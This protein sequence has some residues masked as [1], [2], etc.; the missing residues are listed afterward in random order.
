[1]NFYQLYNLINENTVSQELKKLKKE[2]PSTIEKFLP[3]I[4]KQIKDFLPNINDKSLKTVANWILFLYF[5]FCKQNQIYNASLVTFNRY[6]TNNLVL[7]VHGAY[8]ASQLDNNGNW[9]AILSSKFN[10]PK[11]ALYDLANLDRDYHENLKKK[12]RN[13]PGA[14][15]KTIIEFPDGY[16]WV[17]LEKSYCEKESKSMGHCGNAGASKGDTIL[18]LRDN[19]NVPHLTFILN[20]GILGERKGRANE[21][22]APKYHPYIIELLKLPIIKNLGD[23]KYLPQKDFKISDI[24]EEQL[25]SLVKIKPYF[26]IKYYEEKLDSGEKV[27]E[28]VQ[29]NLIN[30]TNMSNEEKYGYSSLIFKIAKFSESQK[31]LKELY[32]KTFEDNIINKQILTLVLMSNPHIDKEILK[33]IF[34]K[35]KN[36]LQK[37]D[38]KLSK[39]TK[40]ASEADNEILKEIIHMDFSKIG[41]STEDV[42]KYLRVS[43]SYIND[44]SYKSV[45]IT[46]LN[47]MSKNENISGELLITL[48]EDY[49]IYLALSNVNIPTKF[50]EK[51]YENAENT[52]IGKNILEYIVMNKKCPSYILDDIAE[53]P[54]HLYGFSIK[55]TVLNNPNLSKES[56]EK[57]A[58]PKIDKNNRSINYLV[59][60]QDLKSIADSATLKLNRIKS[61]GY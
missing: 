17:D 55:N 25:K 26:E 2:N 56:L 20:N 21:K 3:L 32:Q 34:D 28:D 46:I 16:K 4:Y 47:E 22:P 31:I 7:Y 14:E 6:L 24:T 39:L 19:K 12:Q 37:D 44:G 40:L 48:Y 18:S 5:Y 23:G 13:A 42:A 41:L 9:S 52:K 61:V 58:N 50:L 60:V 38:K 15:G 29:G 10:D 59:R 11:F 53:D 51:V 8:L 27:S 33:D 57:L 35:T 49:D 43:N 45:K 36:P 30:K 54:H 1:M